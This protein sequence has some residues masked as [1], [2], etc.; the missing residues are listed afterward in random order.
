MASKVDEA[1]SYDDDVAVVFDRLSE[2]Y[3][4]GYVEHACLIA[5]VHPGEQA[6]D[7]GTGTGMMSRSLGGLLGGSGKVLGIDIAD[8]MLAFADRRGRKLGLVPHIIKYARGDAEH[9]DVADNSVDLVTSLFVLRHLPQPRKAVDEMRRVLR[10]GGRIV[11]GVGSAAPALSLR[12][13]MYRQQRL[14]AIAKARMGLCLSAPQHLLGLVD[15]Y[16]VDEGRLKGTEGQNELSVRP[17]A[18][19][20]QLLSRAGFEDLRTSWRGYVDD[21]D[22][23]QEFWDVQLHFSSSARY[24]ILGAAPE[25]V[26]RLRS[27]FFRECDAVLDRGGKLVYPHG[28][29]FV[30]GRVSKER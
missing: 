30:C 15:Q 16:L 21:I 24:R 11:V 8:G 17:G 19:T 29:S 5:G 13:A 22:D 28:A 12:G 6:L 4:A 26:E 18:R 14:R 1:A 10:P 2:R 3:S 7:V 27:A 9:L 25:A 23:P 20:A